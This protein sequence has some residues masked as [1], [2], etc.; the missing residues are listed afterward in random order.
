MGFRR[1]LSVAAVVLPLLL[2]S[3]GRG[4]DDVP[5]R[6]NS[7]FVFGTNYNLIYR[8]R[9]DL[10]HLV[11]ARLAEYDSSM[12]VFNPASTISRLNEG[13]SVV[14]DTMMLHV[15]GL[16]KMFHDFS[17]GA[18]D[19]TVE[20][21]SRHWRFTRHLEND[22]ISVE[23]WQA[24][25]D[26]L[27]T[28]MPLVGLDKIS[29]EGNVVRKA[30]RRMKLNANALAEGF[31]ID[32]AASVLEENGV[33][34]YMVEIG[35]EI[36]CS[37]ASPR[38]GK[39]RIGIDSPIEGSNMLNRQNQRIVELTDCAVSTS[40]SYRQCYHVADGRRVQHTIDPRT[41]MPV[42]HTMESVTVVGR[43]TL[44]TDALCTTLM[45]LGPDSA[46]GKV[47]SLPGTEAYI[48]FRDADGNL[49]EQMTDGFRKLIVE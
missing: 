28:V 46:L 23:Q 33:T 10:C 42:A 49:V 3:C 13:D 9:A 15:V 22:T 41:G 11:M 34:D 25:L 47:A 14:A 16:A 2:A 29:V 43:N 21:L 17:G 40:G 31:G 39:W 35:G 6:R 37:G 45:V 32:L 1:I 18:F 30:D 36:H 20:P 48:I 5:F 24:L 4:A 12:S 38:G 44:T 27:D 7:G 19:I 26:G 8:S